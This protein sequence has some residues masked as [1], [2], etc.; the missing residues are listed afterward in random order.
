MPRAS[1]IV[2]GLALLGLQACSHGVIALAQDLPVDTVATPLT[3]AA[4]VIAPSRGFALCLTFEQPGDSRDAA[5]VVVALR[6][7][8]GLVDTL[9]GAPDRTGQRTMCIHDSTSRAY[10]GAMLTAPRRMAFRQVDWRVPPSKTVS[11][12]PERSLKQP[13][14]LC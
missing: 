1:I 2:A 11:R 10:V 5:Q 6:D 7:S 14:A 4:P 13:T 12:A 3:F 8:A 9:R